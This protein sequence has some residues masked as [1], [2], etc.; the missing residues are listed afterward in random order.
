MADR[1]FDGTFFKREVTIN[2]M[3]CNTEN[4][5]FLHY[6]L[7][8]FSE[9]AGDESESKGQTREFFLNAGKVFLIT[10]MSVRFHK[11]LNYSDTLILTTWFR[12]TEGRFFFREFEVRYPDGEL[13]ASATSTWALLDVIEQK[14]VDPNEHPGSTS[15]GID[16]KTDSPECKKIVTASD[17]PTL[18]YRP[19]YY[20]DLDCNRHVNNSAYSRIAT[21]F[22]PYEYQNREVL[23]FVINF[24]RETKLGDTLEIRGSETE[25]GY[26]I[27][28]FCNGFQHYA[29]EFKFL[30]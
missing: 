24:G 9:I 18:G 5:M 19:I 25:D 7:G 15:S 20:T 29:C 8:L 26:I 28:G 27:Q 6:M 3:Q 2:H 11:T 14:T 21:D 12:T 17:L 16:R 13:V 4:K 30:A 10:R 23:D 22:L 1:W